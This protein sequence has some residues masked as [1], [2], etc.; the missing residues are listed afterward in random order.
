[1]WQ[2]ELIYIVGLIDHVELIFEAISDCSKWE[3]IA[4][5]FPLFHGPVTELWTSSG[6]YADQRKILASDWML[7]M[8]SS[9]DIL[10]LL[11]VYHH[12]HIVGMLES[13]QV[14]NSSTNR[15]WY[16]TT[17]KTEFICSS[18]NHRSIFRILDH[19]FVCSVLAAPLASF[20]TLDLPVL[21]VNIMLAALVCYKL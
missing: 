21:I 6:W 1:M 9:L 13:I 7:A 3:F 18:P 16:T 17:C 19:R 12:K 4:L 2:C 5:G 14:M 10:D 15:M 8:K 20:E 11:C